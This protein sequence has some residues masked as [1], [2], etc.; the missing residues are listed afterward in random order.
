MS[1]SRKGTFRGKKESEILRSPRWKK[2]R[3]K[4]RMIKKQR[5]ES[6][7]SR[8]INEIEKQKDVS[9]LCHRF[10]KSGKCW[11]RGCQYASKKLCRR[12][13]VEGICRY[14]N[15]EG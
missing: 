1:S 15:E 6:T 13:E 2:S 7:A 14:Y 12:I 11:V 9:Q 5:E 3:S 4:G 10:V 8:N